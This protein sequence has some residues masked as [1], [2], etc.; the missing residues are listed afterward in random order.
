MAQLWIPG[1]IPV[2]EAV[3]AAYSIE[4][5]SHLAPDFK[6]AFARSLRGMRA[7]WGAGES[8]QPFVL[9]GSG[10]LAMECAAVNLVDPGDPVLVVNIGVFGARMAEMLRRRGADVREVVVE[11]GVDVDLEAVEQALADGPRVLF[12]THVDTSTG[13]R[14]D[15]QGLAALA[16]RY[17]ALSCFDGICSVGGERIEQER[18]G[19]DVVFT[20]SQKAIGLPAG[21]ALLVCSEAALTRRRA[22]RSAPPLVLDWL[23]WLPIMEAYEAEQNSY[24]GTPATTLVPALDVGL[25]ELLD[26]GREAVFARHARVAETVRFRFREAGL[27]W[28]AQTPANTMSG[29]YWPDGVGPEALGRIKANGV[30]VAGGL[31]PALKTSMFRMGHMGDAI[32][33][34]EAVER[35]LEAVVTGIFGS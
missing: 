15:L 25:A 30:V 17:G 14:V 4:P 22:L 32:R 19:A 23:E 27:R 2:S 31:H 29:V 12:A 18:W 34:Q 26:E 5:P 10:T 28:V 16:R 33:D 7:V 24:F 6:A 8:Y 1:P 11:P 21:L 9:V 13:A 3:V 35:A 20:A